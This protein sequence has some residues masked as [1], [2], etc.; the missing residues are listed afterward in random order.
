MKFDKSGE[1]RVLGVFLGGT[2]SCMICSLVD[3]DTTCCYV[4]L[5]YEL[6]MKF[7]LKRYD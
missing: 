6:P 4:E 2:Y 5:C 3:D 1:Q 7:L